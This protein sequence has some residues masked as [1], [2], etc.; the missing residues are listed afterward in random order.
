MR[1]VHVLFENLPSLKGTDA[2]LRILLAEKA[3]L[4]NV[5][6]EWPEANLKVRV[7]WKG[8]VRKEM[9]V[10]EMLVIRV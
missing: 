2:G 8:S 6:I 10:K 3:G 7:L 4:I 9:L 5:K 1:F